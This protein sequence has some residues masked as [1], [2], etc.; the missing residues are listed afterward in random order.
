VVELKVTPLKKEHISQIRFYMNY[1]DENIRRN[2]QNKTIGI[3]MVRENNKY[4]IKYLFDEKIKS[5][6][7]KLV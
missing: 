2:F 5:I 4:V 7:Y 6:E 1:V 3:L